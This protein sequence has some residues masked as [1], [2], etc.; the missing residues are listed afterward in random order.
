MP[1][2]RA[3]IVPR[4][5]WFG[6]MFSTAALLAGCATGGLEPQST[7]ESPAGLKISKSVSGMAVSAA[8]WPTSN[9]WEAFGDSQL[10]ALVNEALTD[11]PGLRAA[12]AR[13]RQALSV[14]ELAESG[15]DP[16]LDA[17]LSSTRERFS[18]NG[19]TP[20]PVAGTWQTLNQGLLSGSYELDFW[21]KNAAAVE[22]AVGRA[23]AIEVDA[24]AVRLMIS[25]AVVQ[26]YIAFDQTSKQLVI[27]HQL[28]DQQNQLLGLTQ[29]RLAAEI[30]SKVELTQS[31][32]LLPAT[33]ANIAALNESIELSRN[34][35]AALLGKGP[36]RGADIALPQLQ[37]PPSTAIPGTLTA[38]LIGR[39]PDVVAQ[40][41]RVEASSR[42]IDLAKA[43]F[44]PNVSITT[45]LGLQSL[46]FPN[47]DQAS[48]RILGI[49]PAITLPIFDGGRLR[50]NLAAQD[51]AYDVAVEAY[52]Q[53]LLDA[54]QDIADQLSSLKWLQE[55]LVEQRQAVAVAAR[56]DDLAQKRYDGGLATY[57]QVLTTQNAILAQRRQLVVLE[58]RAF[59][60]QAN[61]SRAFG[62]GYTPGAEQQH[63]AAN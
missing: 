6:F 33:R 28:L 48:S 51:A 49:G 37:L 21:G 52:N 1:G 20:H 25:S 55:R 56:A 3:R 27:E 45:F 30:D 50:A 23:R 13:I 11:S 42:D 15:L 40:R 12:A 53:T 32:A 38:D 10:N 63:A 31:E 44:Y 7:M 16:H 18:S 5:T 24:Q 39:R 35:L 9:W 26:A 8:A 46:G 36:D 59:A 22:A 2:Q 47:F 62:G 17:S 4:A 57:I 34:R 61:L 60:L 19:T 58:S 29:R 43:R 54:V 14:Q 41:W